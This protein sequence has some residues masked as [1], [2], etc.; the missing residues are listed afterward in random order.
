MKYPEVLLYGTFIH[1]YVDVE[2]V[3]APN[4]L[5]KFNPVWGTYLPDPPSISADAGDGDAAGAKARSSMPLDN[6]TI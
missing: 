4:L 6:P 3:R 2:F 5:T 1:L